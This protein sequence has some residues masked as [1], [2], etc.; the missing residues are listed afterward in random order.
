[1]YFEVDCEDRGQPLDAELLNG[2]LWTVTATTR[3]LC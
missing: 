2:I 3:I 1:M